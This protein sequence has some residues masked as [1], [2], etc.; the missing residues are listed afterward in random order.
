MERPNDSVPPMRDVWHTYESEKRRIAAL[1]LSP[2][3]YMMELLR[4]A[5]RLGI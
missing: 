5:R 4:L 3:E 2:S 1:G